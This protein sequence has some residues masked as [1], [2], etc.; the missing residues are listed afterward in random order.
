MSMIPLHRM[1][2]CAV[3]GTEQ[4]EA[5]VR[6][7]YGRVYADDDPQFRS[8]FPDDMESAIQNLSDFLVQRFGGPPRY[9]ERKGPPA[10]RARH[11]RFSITRPMVE[12]WLAH[13]RAA[14]EEVH[15]PEDL[16]APMDGFFTETAHFLQN[17]DGE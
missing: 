15:I 11:A 1:N 10:L 14:M 3:L 5:L 17:S 16:R 13:M 9:S 2:I 12:R 7:F 8:M 6:A 4:I